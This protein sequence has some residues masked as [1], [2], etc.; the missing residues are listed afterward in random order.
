MAMEYGGY[1]WLRVEPGDK[2]RWIQ[3]YVMLSADFSLL[4]PADRVCEFGSG[5]FSFGRPRGSRG[6]WSGA[7]KIS[8][9]G[10]GSIHV[11]VADKLG[12]CLVGVAIINFRL[13]PIARGN[14]QS[15]NPIWVEIMDMYAR[16]HSA[17][18]DWRKNGL[19]PPP[20]PPEGMPERLPDDPFPNRF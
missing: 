13:V 9:Y 14:E 3:E 10:A 2:W 17:Y 8:A 4:C 1:R 11:R 16:V 15:V 5:M 7:K 20:P 6:K 19:P 12:P 18:Q